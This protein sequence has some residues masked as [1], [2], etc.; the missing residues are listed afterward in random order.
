MS[1]EEEEDGALTSDELLEN[2]FK[3]PECVLPEA[4]AE[5]GVGTNKRE[6]KRPGQEGKAPAEERKAPGP[7]EMKEPGF[8]NFLQSPSK[9]SQKIY[10]HTDT[11]PHM[12]THTSRSEKSF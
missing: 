4:G 8:D 1:A 12:Y 7:E 10:L 6:N 2:Y 3:Q 5:V 11:H 9:V